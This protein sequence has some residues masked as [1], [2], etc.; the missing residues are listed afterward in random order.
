M[1]SM[2]AGQRKYRKGSGGRFETCP[3]C[4]NVVAS[5]TGS[6][7][8]TFIGESAEMSERATSWS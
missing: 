8:G 1:S 6:T 3:M 5:L 7:D 4:W 2:G